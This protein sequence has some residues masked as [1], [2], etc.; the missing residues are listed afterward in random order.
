MVTIFFVTVLTIVGEL[1]PPLKSAI[2]NLTGHHWVTKGVL[3]IVVMVVVYI[4]LR[5][6]KMPVRES[7]ISYIGVVL[8][9]LVCSIAL[10]LFFAIHYL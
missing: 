4:L 10:A 1:M 5:A 2:A 7:D 9:V 3:S 8:S 6:R